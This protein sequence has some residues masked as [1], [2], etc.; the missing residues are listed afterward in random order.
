MKLIKKAFECTFNDWYDV[1]SLGVTI[2]FESDWINSMIFH[3]DSVGQAKL[4]YINWME[5]DAYKYIDVKARRC[6]HKDLVLG[7][8]H[9]LLSSTSESQQRKMLHA[10]GYDENRLSIFGYRN[11][12]QCAVNDDWE[13]LIKLGLADKN[14]NNGLNY[15][16]LTDLGRQVISSIVPMERYKFE[17]IIT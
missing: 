7:E 5:D 8:Q 13:S 11:Y 16:F 3:A 9:P 10:L 2:H 14:L 6:K 17:L 1:D 4:K 12:Y 15:Y